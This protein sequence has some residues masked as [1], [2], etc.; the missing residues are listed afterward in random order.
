MPKKKSKKRASI[1]R[2][3]NAWTMS[4]AEL[5]SY[6]MSWLRDKSRWWKPKTRAVARAR[7][8]PWVYKCEECWKEGKGKLPPLPWKKRQRNNADADH[9]NSV[10]PVE[11]FTKNANTFLWYDWTE[12]IRRLFV[13]EDLYKTLCWEC[14]TNKTKKE[15]EERKKYRTQPNQ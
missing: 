14:H 3:Y 11:G 4:E 7:V 12:V 1:L 5:R 9:I 8:K 13:E 6:I 15:N 10:I 2:E